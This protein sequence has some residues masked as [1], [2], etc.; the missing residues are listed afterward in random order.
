MVARRAAV[1]VA[2]AIARALQHNPKVKYPI[3]VN[4]GAADTILSILPREHF[5]NKCVVE[6]S[7]GAGGLT[8]RL[9]ETNPRRL[10]AV[11][12]S[13]KLLVPLREVAS[14]NPERIT[15]IEN[16]F[17]QSKFYAELQG[18]EF[19]GCEVK[20]PWQDEAQ[21]TAIGALN[22]KFGDLNLTHLV[23][24][25]A[26]RAGLH[27]FGRVPL[28]LFVSKT[29][30]KKVFAEPGTHTRSRIAVIVNSFAEAERLQPVIPLSHYPF[31]NELELLRLVPR[32]EPLVNV[33]I[34]DLEFVLRNIFCLKA[35]KIGQAI[36]GLSPSYPSLLARVPSEL[37]DK[38]VQY[39]TD[40]ELCEVAKA[41]STWEQKPAVSQD[42]FWSYT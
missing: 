33:P 26:D 42:E 36:K 29:V 14:K 7:A 34:E 21:I 40:E 24:W 13:E 41:F 9:L 23:R 6:I 35:A 18:P 4:N 27:A 31:S 1:Q 17:M 37:H 2:A 12:N 25:M 11:E 32:K 22:Y 10:V 19:L 15:V 39:C 38:V 3:F 16:D 8:S 5:A 28:Y 20:T 30:T